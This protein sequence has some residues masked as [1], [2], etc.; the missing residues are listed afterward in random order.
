MDKKGILIGMINIMRRL[1][2]VIDISKEMLLALCQDGNYSWIALLAC[3]CQD[4]TFLPPL[5]IYQSTTNDVRDTWVE[6][7]DPTNQ[8]AYLGYPATMWR[9]EVELQQW[10]GS[11]KIYDG[12]LAPASPLATQVAPHIPIKNVALDLSK[13]CESENATR[14]I[15]GW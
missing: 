8:E 7:F 14:S 2:H 3:I 4:T 9:M 5:L 10:L 11:C 1:F 6:D 12:T 13:E 15:F